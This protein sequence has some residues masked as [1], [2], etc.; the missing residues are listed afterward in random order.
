MLFST[1]SI[2]KRIFQ[3][4]NFLHGHH[5]GTW[6]DREWLRKKETV[7]L[8][9][10]IA[11]FALRDIAARGLEGLVFFGCPPQDRNEKINEILSHLFIF[12]AETERVHQIVRKNENSMARELKQAFINEL[13]DGAR[14]KDDYRKLYRN[15]QT[16]IRESNLFS[17]PDNPSNK[18][19]R[20]FCF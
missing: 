3:D 7:P 17:S 16:G 15:A 9:Q 4:N 2:Y 14:K 20:G 8:L 13:I 10:K 5:R 1:F 6:K 11:A 12:I 19:S 18:G